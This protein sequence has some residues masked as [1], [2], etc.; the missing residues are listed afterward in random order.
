MAARQVIFRF[1]TASDHN[2][3]T[4]T[5]VP[6]VL[7]LVSLVAAWIPARRAASIDP[8]AALRME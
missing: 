5:L 6:A 7:V 1:S 4:F 2:A 8:T 3:V